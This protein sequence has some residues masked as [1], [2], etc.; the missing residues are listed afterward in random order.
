MEVRQWLML[1]EKVFQITVGS[2]ESKGKGI[3]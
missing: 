1:L 2:L 3:R